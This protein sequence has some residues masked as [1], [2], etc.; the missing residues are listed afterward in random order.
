MAEDERFIRQYAGI[1]KLSRRP[2]ARSYLKLNYFLMVLLGQVLTRR[3]ALVIALVV[4]RACQDLLMRRLFRSLSSAPI[5]PQ[6]Q[7]NRKEPG[8][9]HLS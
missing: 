7:V 8:Q 1:G 9:L 3:R 5:G 6:N 2:L 4:W